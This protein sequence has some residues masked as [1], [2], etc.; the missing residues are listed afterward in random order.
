MSDTVSLAE[1][2]TLE[3]G[4]NITGDPVGVWEKVA[5]LSDKYDFYELQKRYPIEKM[6]DE[7]STS[8]ELARQRGQELTSA[9][10]QEE[11]ENLSKKYNIPFEFTD[12][13]LPLGKT[14]H[15]VQDEAVGCYSNDAT[16]RG[17][18]R[19]QAIKDKILQYKRMGVKCGVSLD[20]AQIE[21]KEPILSGNGETV[22]Q[23]LGADGQVKRAVNES[24]TVFFYE[25]KANGEGKYLRQV[26]DEN[27][28]TYLRENGTK[29][30]EHFLRCGYDEPEEVFYREDETLE[31]EIISGSGE[32][33]YY[34]KEGKNIVRAE[35][36]KGKLIF[37]VDEN[38]TKT[39]YYPD[40][41]TV[42]S[43]NYADGSRK[44]YGK[45]VFAQAVDGVSEE[46]S[47]ELT[48]IDREGNKT[49]YKGWTENEVISTEDVKGNKKN[50]KDSV[51][52]R[53]YDAES[54]ISKEFY[55]DGKTVKSASR[56]GK[57]VYYSRENKALYATDI[58]GTINGT[59]GTVAGLG[60][61][62]KTVAWRATQSHGEF[63]FAT[64][65]NAN[66]VFYEGG[67]VTKTVDA[68]GN[69]TR[70]NSASEKICF[71]SELGHIKHSKDGTFSIFVEEGDLFGDITY[72]KNGKL[73][74]YADKMDFNTVYFKE[75]GKTVD[76]IV[77]PL[78][79]DGK[80]VNAEVNIDINS[81]RGKAVL[82]GLDEAIEKRAPQIQEYVQSEKVVQEFKDRMQTEFKRYQEDIVE[83]GIS[84][85]P[86]KGTEQVVAKEAE[87]QAEQAVTSATEKATTKSAMK[88]TAAKAGEK[89]AKTAKTAGKAAK[90]TLLAANKAYDDTFDAIMKWGD[91]HAPQWM[92]KVEEKTVQ[93]AAEK[94]M[95]T[96]SGQAIAKQIEKKVGKEVAA[97][98]AKKIPILCLGVGAVCVYDR[99]KEGEYLKA[100]GEG[101]SALVA[102]VP[103]LG[104]LASF[105][106]DGAMLSDD[107][108][109]F[110]HGVMPKDPNS[111]VA[112]EST[113]VAQQ[114]VA[115]KKFVRKVDKA[116]EAK[117]KAEEE[118]KKAESKKKAQEFEKNLY[119]YGGNPSKDSWGR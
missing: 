48:V 94:F 42:R 46:A 53:E 15:I 80:L 96:K 99:V 38:K 93:K 2:M 52:T 74:S 101:A 117:K 34:D 102:N 63:N 100:V 57:T 51:L 35:T 111:H 61:D 45:N 73:L 109:V 36:E 6:A 82:G 119:Q 77:G 19:S 28:E 30:R 32:Q 64:D 3:T 26:L 95:K 18:Q 67:E 9:S 5:V 70:Y 39:T 113:F 112:A 7:L 106:L 98:I 65:T 118:K 23:K 114:I 116:A 110:E 89:V 105:G 97:S 91:K 21:W 92:N 62:G 10:L 104:T 14:V 41:E 107:L 78:Y 108:K 103:G 68:K 33:H 4:V 86:V 87:K 47:K 20:N 16:I 40:G 71:H 69:E 84:K 75:D 12:K 17:K 11:V 29:E 58:H 43:V 37:T 66:Q 79:E 25:D 1:L 44:V 88:A 54:G 56:K 83:D 50:Y 22:L 13:E 115:E 27:A 31:K 24:G 60:D 8:I 90:E 49:V 55:E 81:E 85:A 59:A 76:R 72:D